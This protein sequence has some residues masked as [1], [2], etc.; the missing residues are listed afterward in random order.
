MYRRSMSVRVFGISL[1][2]Q[3]T[4][5]DY[6]LENVHKGGRDNIYYPTAH[7]SPFT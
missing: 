4:F 1:K 5:S 2:L 7:I 6:A 3:E